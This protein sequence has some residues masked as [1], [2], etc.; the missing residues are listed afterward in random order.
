MQLSRASGDDRG[1]TITELS[2][3]SLVVAITMAI[4]LNLFSGFFNNVQV[5]YDLEDVERVSRPVIRE[6][7]IQA[8]QSIARGEDGDLH[9][10]AE[11]AWNKL[12]F[13]SDRLP[14]DDGGAPEL[15]TYEL[16]NCSKGSEGGVCAL[17]L[18]VV[19]AD[20]PGAD[21]W[22]YTGAASL[23]RIELENV[24]ADDPSV[25]SDGAL[26]VGMEWTGDPLTETE[27]G[28]CKE[29]TG[30]PCD[31]E[32]VQIRLRVDP[33]LAQ[34]NPRVFEIEESVRLRNA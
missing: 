8:R 27:V 10:V 28:S 30:T 29:G 5:V 15:H 21:T 16:I 23:Q 17:Q 7:V 19:P 32:V 22:T 31:I 12:A 24:L 11:L 13:Y 6:L 18:T 34:E 4:V 1:V 25:V 3:V 26:F 14:Y 9:P 33:N 20:D 2:V